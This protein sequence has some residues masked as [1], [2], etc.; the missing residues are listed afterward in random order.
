MHIILDAM[1]GD[2]APLE[3]LRGAVLAKEAC[4]VSLT[5]VGHTEILRRTA[6]ENGLSLDG[7]RLEHAESVV[8]ME[9]DPFSV[10]RAKKDSSMAVA[11]RLLQKEGDALVSA[12]STGALHIGSALLIRTIPG[13][14]RSAIATLLPLSRPMLFLDSGANPTVTAEYL[15]QWAAMGSVYMKNVFGVAAP[16]VGL[17]NN[18]AE[19]HK[20]TPVAVE[21]H[22][23][24]AASRELHFIGNVEGNQ[25][26]EAPCDVLVSDGFTGNVA[27]KL[28]EGMGKYLLTAMAQ[29]CAQNPALAPSLGAI[30]ETLGALR[31][32]FDASE[33]GGAPLL[34]LTKPV[35]K[36]HGSSDA[37]A[38][39]SAVRQAAS[40]AS[41]GVIGE[42]AD[43]VRRLES[44]G[45]TGERTH[46][47]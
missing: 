15:L 16:S 36:A 40:F 13:V 33:H 43:F 29:A 20:G 37:R 30:R 27:L 3:V 32:R 25:L 17:L 6:E 10:V 12:G 35:V 41:T 44:G 23:L 11:L 31:G 28:Y 24:L 39:A 18:G 9:D 2:R 19:P 8:T 22:R 5:L 1:G 38:I 45:E 4:G 46:E 34:G 47:N 21:A 7:L 14:H 42:I 26:I